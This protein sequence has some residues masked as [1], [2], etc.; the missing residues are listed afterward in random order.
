MCCDAHHIAFVFYRT[1]NREEN[2]AALPSRYVKFL[3]GFVAFMIFP[4][5]S[6][7]LAFFSEHRACSPQDFVHRSLHI[8]DLHADT[9]RRK[10]LLRGT[11]IK[12][13]QP[14]GF[15]HH[16][17]RIEFL[18]GVRQNLMRI[19]QKTRNALQMLFVRVQ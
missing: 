3:Q 18:N 1:A 14:V 13:L 5:D 11:R 7:R 15:K 17:I 19:V 9:G 12:I 16:I 4:N 8:Q 6:L 2:E 10:N